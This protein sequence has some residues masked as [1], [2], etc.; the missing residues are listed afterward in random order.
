MT[1]EPEQVMRV[2]LDRLNW[3]VRLARWQTAN[4]FAK[5]FASRQRAIA[6]RAYLDW[7]KSRKFEMEVVSGL[8]VLLCTAPTPCRRPTK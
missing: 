8:S 3:P 5:L 4:E 6:T 1:M 2:L 7:L